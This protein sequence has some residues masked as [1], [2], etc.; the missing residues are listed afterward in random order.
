MQ[1]KQVCST[2]CSQLWWL[3]FASDP[4]DWS[5]PA[6]GW[7]MNSNKSSLPCFLRYFV[8]VT[9]NWLRGHIN[10]W[11]THSSYT[12][13]ETIRKHWVWWGYRWRQTVAELL[14][15]DSQFIWL[16][17][18]SSSD[19]RQFLSLPTVCSTN[20][21]LK[22]GKKEKCMSLQTVGNHG[23]RDAST[24]RFSMLWVGS[25]KMSAHPLSQ[26]PPCPSF[27]CQH[28][29]VLSS[30][31]LLSSTLSA[32]PS[33]VRPQIAMKPRNQAH[34]LSCR[35]TLDNHRFLIPPRVV[36]DKKKS[37]ERVT[38]MELMG[39]WIYACLWGFKL[40]TW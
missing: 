29:E 31:F 9:E 39:A 20:R 12:K 17:T 6:M 25:S 23:C 2:A 19:C 10:P 8:T 5:Q 1:G 35:N 28:D 3:S 13:H 15:S 4:Q 40:T 22:S 32:S 11:G 36:D 37:L 34:F 26:S 21:A 33:P 38:W 7:D 24:P 16:Q 14:P 27:S 18:P 30:T